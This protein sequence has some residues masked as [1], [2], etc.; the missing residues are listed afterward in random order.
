MT[1]RRRCE[2]TFPRPKRN[3]YPATITQPIDALPN[4]VMTFPQPCWTLPA[5]INIIRPIVF[6][7]WWILERLGMSSSL[8][9]LQLLDQTGHDVAV[10]HILHSYCRNLFLES[11]NYTSLDVYQKHQQYSQTTQSRFNSISSSEWPG[12]SALDSCRDWL[13]K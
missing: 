7:T 6:R 13:W 12:F 9:T 11:S 2:I 3:L 1:V 4:Q 8:T 10:L 5:T